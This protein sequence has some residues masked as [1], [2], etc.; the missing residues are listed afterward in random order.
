MKFNFFKDS[1]FDK[2]GIFFRNIGFFDSNSGIAITQNGQILLTSLGTIEIGRENSSITYEKE[3]EININ[4][5]YSFEL[6]Q[7]FPNPFNPK[8]VIKFTIP[9]NTFVILKVYD[10]LGKEVITLVNETLE[11][12]NHSINFNGTSLSSGIYL[13]KI[14][15]GNFVQQ[16]QMLLIK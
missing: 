1:I 9:E 16:R 8:T 15:A 6:F 13:Y 10:V 12:G 2:D 4:E 7:N 14:F 11:R 5:N 3:L